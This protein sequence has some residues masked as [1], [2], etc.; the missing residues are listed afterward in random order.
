M[1]NKKRGSIRAG[2]PE[3]K[4][5]TQE[6]CWSAFALYSAE[7]NPC[8]LVYRTERQTSALDV[9][10]VPPFAKQTNIEVLRA[11]SLC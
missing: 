9:R 10:Q 7:P 8:N 11:L 4:I 1:A 5:L 6:L 3:S 2:L